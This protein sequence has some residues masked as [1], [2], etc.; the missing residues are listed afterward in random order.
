MSDP[1]T[2]K[3][4]SKGQVVA[5]TYSVSEATSTLSDIVY[6][7]GIL[8][9]KSDLGYYIGAVVG[10]L[11]GVA[12]FFTTRIFQGRSIERAYEEQKAEAKRVVNLQNS[13]GT[14]IN[15]SDNTNGDEVIEGM[16][17]EEVVE[18]NKDV[19]KEVE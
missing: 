18:D 9:K 13:V 17:T 8:F 3:K 19:S 16:F 2:C 10:V 14:S 11:S 5:T 4:P 6:S 15:S 7:F 12:E 1:K